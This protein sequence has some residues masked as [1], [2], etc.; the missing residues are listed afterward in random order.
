MFK[1]GIGK[2]ATYG[3]YSGTSVRGSRTQPTIAIHGTVQGG[4]A[5]VIIPSLVIVNHV[6]HMHLVGRHTIKSRE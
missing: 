5:S 3:W 6:R 2:N 1:C 4:Y